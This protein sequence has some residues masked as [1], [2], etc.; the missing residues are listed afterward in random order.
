MNKRFVR[1]GLEYY[2]EVEPQEGQDYEYHMLM[3]NRISNLLPL[4]REKINDK[5]M[6]IYPVNHVKP[7]WITTEKMWISGR[8]FYSIVDSLIKT[9][10]EVRRYLLKPDNLVLE[11]D[12]LF[13][14]L[15][16]YQLHFIY[17]P[18][19]QQDIFRQM[20]NFVEKLLQKIEHRDK[21]GIS[22]AY[23]L[24]HLL[25][26]GT[27]DI[28]DL[29]EYLGNFTTGD[30]ADGNLSR[31]ETAYVPGINDIRTPGINH[32]RTPGING[33]RMQETIDTRTQKTMDS[34]RQKP[35]SARTDEKGKDKKKTD[36]N[37]D[38]KQ[39][40][41]IGRMILL[42][43]CA[44]IFL[45]GLLVLFYM[46]YLIY[47]HGIEAWKRNVLLAVGFV[48]L[49]DGIVLL[50][51][52]K[53]IKKEKELDILMDEMK[54]KT[55]VVPVSI[56][57]PETYQSEP[58]QPETH[59]SKPYQPEM[60]Q[61]EPYQPETTVLN[62]NYTAQEERETCVRL[63]GKGTNPVREIRIDKTPFVIGN[64]H[65]GIDYR[66]E[67]SQ[68]SRFHVSILERSGEYYI[69]DLHSTNGTRVCGVRLELDEERLL[70]HGDEVM[71][72]DL[73]FSF[74]KN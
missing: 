4:Q 73:T 62:W 10:E 37:A 22:F 64:Y 14:E 24:Y 13:W 61:P 50:S 71:L 55:A 40:N 48:L 69:K 30:R 49:L 8:Q 42:A 16:R 26:E 57:Q 15:D 9:I 27:V 34:R 28:D 23:G 63:M 41:E 60:Y 74:E 52:W 3:E 67:R 54:I 66:I 21:E 32:T 38:K 53:K 39:K 56:H 44:V 68:I 45:T 20:I 43:V 5:V 6:L 31:T 19:Y 72:A 51:Q 59:Q 70:S 12:C 47:W 11:M 2:M 17:L 36:K 18:G 25:K 7:F 1:N 46:L 29:K 65:T 35:S 58:C 33:T